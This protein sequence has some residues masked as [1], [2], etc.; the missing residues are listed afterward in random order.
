MSAVPRSARA[1]SQVPREMAASTTPKINSPR[2]KFSPH[3]LRTLIKTT[4][5]CASK[6]GP[7]P[8]PLTPQS[9]SFHRVLPERRL[10][11]TRKQSQLLRDSCSK[12]TTNYATKSKFG[13][14]TRKRLIAVKNPEEASFT[15]AVLNLLL[16]S[17]KV[18]A[19][20]RG[21]CLD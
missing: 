18:S 17:K 16:I 13:E 10:R 11:Q 4:T 3:Y 1:F 6:I 21:K 7:H 20:L 15:A 5:L 12:R 14:M 2:S 9:Q 8:Q 19:I